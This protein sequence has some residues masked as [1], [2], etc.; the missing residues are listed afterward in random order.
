MDCTW[1]QTQ[2]LYKIYEET[3]LSR[4]GPT[5]GGSYRIYH[6][7][8]TTADDLVCRHLRQVVL[9]ALSMEVATEMRQKARKLTNDLGV[10]RSLAQLK[11]QF[12]GSM[13]LQ[14][15]RRLR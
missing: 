9:V 3:D 10:T 2:R 14:E 13:L 7:G 6:Q 5:I 8:P 4:E 15:E 12:W 1:I 11:L